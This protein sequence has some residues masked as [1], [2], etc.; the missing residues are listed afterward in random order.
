MK[1]NKQTLRI[2]LAAEAVVIVC[3]CI[4]VGGVVL[5]NGGFLGTSSAPAAQPVVQPA[6]V[7]VTSI[8]PV[9]ETQAPVAESTAGPSGSMVEN[10]PEGVTKY[11]DYDAGFEA[12]I[13][14]GWLAVRPNSDEFKIALVD[15]AASNQM[16][17][18]Q[19]TTDQAQYDAEF[20]RL[21]LYI[22]RPDIQPDV[23]FGMS[24]LA[25]DAKDDTKLD[26]KTLGTLLRGL[27]SSNVIPG[28]RTTYSNIMENGN[29]VS[30]IIIKGRYSMDDGQGGSIPFFTTLIVFKPSPAS[31][32][33]MTF[34]FMKDYEETISAD[35]DALIESIKPIGQ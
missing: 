33:R 11:T 8:L 25:W 21:Y 16:L 15:A 31:T 6:D 12:T 35:M 28:F 1:M 7:A 32:A 4:G 5:Y 22:L 10:L 20:D 2:V 9:A 14:I 17:R 23:M 24:K 13:P 29:G 3:L 18:Q 34:S 26:N 30:L 19:M 27:E